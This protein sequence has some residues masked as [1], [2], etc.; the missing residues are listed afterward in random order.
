MPDPVADESRIVIGRVLDD[1]E[2]EVATE[3]AGLGSTD[4]EYWMDAAGP[5]SG[6]TERTRTPEQVDEKCLGLVVGRVTRQCI[7]PDQLLASSSGPSF[8]IGTVI[9]RGLCGP[10]ARAES[11]G[12][13]GHDLRFTPRSGPKPMV[14]VYDVHDAPCGRGQSQE[15]Q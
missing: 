4:G 1:D 5:H 8:E 15:R 11:F 7:D 6:Q 2:S 13:V 9:E 3:A 14:D 12:C 10:E